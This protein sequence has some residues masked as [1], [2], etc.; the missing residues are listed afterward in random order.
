[1]FSCDVYARVSKRPASDSEDT[2]SQ[3]VK[4][5]VAVCLGGLLEHLE[6]LEHLPFHGEL[7]VEANAIFTQKVENDRLGLAE[8]DVLKLE[9][10]AADRLSLVVGILLVAGSQRK[11]VNQ[12]HGCG[13]LPVRHDIAFQLLVVVGTD[14]VNVLLELAG[15]LKLLEIGLALDSA[16]GG[17]HD[18]LV[19]AVDVLLP[20]GKPSGLVVVLD[21]LPSMALGRVGHL[22]LLADVDGN[23]LGQDALLDSSRLGV[24]ATATKKAG[25]FD[26][27]IAD[28]FL[29]SIPLA[30]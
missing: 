20:H 17:Q 23:L 3:P 28:L 25:R 1:M 2:Y 4:D 30:V 27:E 7:V 16:V 14:P 21:R 9:R 11:P 5:V 29:P 19:V 8:R 12:V 13:A 24:F 15:L 26:A 22:G 6:V 10:A 18:V